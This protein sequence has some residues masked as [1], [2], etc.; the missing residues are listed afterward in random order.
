M[1]AI[2]YNGT[3]C[4]D[5]DT[6][7]VSALSLS[8]L[9]GYGVFESMTVIDRQAFAL[10]RHLGRLRTSLATL[11]L[12]LAVSDAQLRDA[13]ATVLAH[14]PTA[15]KVRITVAAGARLDDAPV[16]TV[17]TLAL[18]PWPA[19]TNVVISPW[20]RNE[21]APSAGAKTTSY[22]DNMLA[23][24]HAK[25][26][27]A[28]EAILCDSK[29]NLS[30]GTASNLFLVR[31]GT[32]YT[33]SLANGGLGG[34]TRELIMELVDTVER[35]DLRGED[36][37]TANEAFLTSSTRGVHPIA[38]VDGVALAHVYGP[39]TQAADAALTALQARTLDP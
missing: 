15:T 11:E 35:V 32:L 22:A 28:D 38:T 19:S 39:V 24:R 36:L 2:W 17:H 10:S 34:M 9:V 3:F 13:V 4:E 33:P 1:T 26:L 37:V 25:R 7:T 8:S 18:A 16:V 21:R 30:E 12:T 23:Q 14:D 31:D 27:G 6:A 20:V 29:G 5:P